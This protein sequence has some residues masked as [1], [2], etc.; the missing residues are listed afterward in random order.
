MP[1]SIDKI[2]ERKKPAETSGEETD[3]DKFY[4]IL[5]GEGLQENFF[6][7]RFRDGN[8]ICFSYADLMFFDYDPEGRINLEFGGYCVILEGRGLHPKLFQGIKSKRVAWVKES[9]TEM[10]DHKDNEIFIKEI[11]LVLPKDS[12]GDDEYAEK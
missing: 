2:L 12:K 10:Q 4:S 9:D 11:R 6:E 5:V 1:D 7:V 8:I 3:A